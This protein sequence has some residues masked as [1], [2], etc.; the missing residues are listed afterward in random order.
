M[1]GFHKRVGLGDNSM[2]ASEKKTKTPS[3]YQNPFFKRDDPELMWLIV[4]PKSPPKSKKRNAV[5]QDDDADDVYDAESPTHQTHGEEDKGALSRGHRPPLLMAQEET[6]AVSSISKE[7]EVAL[8]E[9]LARIQR[10]QQALAESV[11]QLQIERDQKAVAYQEMH[12]KHENS[13]NAILTF[14]ATIYNRSLEG[15]NGQHLADMFKAPLTRDAPHQGNVVEVDN[16]EPTSTPSSAQVQQRVRRPLLLQAPP[17]NENS[18]GSPVTV[19]TPPTAASSPEFRSTNLKPVQGSENH[20]SSN[21]HTPTTAPSPAQ[22]SLGYHSEAATPGDTG[23]ATT[24][25]D[26]VM[27]SYLNSVNNGGSFPNAR[28]DFSQAFPQLETSSGNSSLT[29]AQQSN[30]LQSI[31]NASKHMSG[32]PSANDEDLQALGRSLQEQSS[33]IADVYRSLSPLS[34]S[35]SIPGLDDQQYMGAPGDHDIL[36]NLDHVFTDQDYFGDTT[37][38]DP[39]S[40]FD[41]TNSNLDFTTAPPENFDFSNS[42]QFVGGNGFANNQFDLASQNGDGRTI[43]TIPSSE[44]TSPAN[45]VDDLLENGGA[46]PRKRLRRR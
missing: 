8:K 30:A 29:P 6:P 11:R 40:A 1:Y 41:F 28:M 20:Y 31:T 32:Y 37:A 21:G 27:S 43:E 19:S 35:G 42:P 38:A 24:P 46:S 34:P 36:G 17:S 25:F 3:E 22:E 16:F 33:E 26:Q 9:T 15:A 13:I 5:D 10:N 4:K 23:T 39:A 45:T 2:R 14:L 7:Q 12:K 44:A 18:S